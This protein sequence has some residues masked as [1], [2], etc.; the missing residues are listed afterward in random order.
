[1]F[2][3]IKWRSYKIGTYWLNKLL[4]IQTLIGKKSPIIEHN[5]MIEV[6]LVFRWLYD[7]MKL[8]NL[9]K[10]LV[11]PIYFFDFYN[12]IVCM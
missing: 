9:I 2:K 11:Y 7:I 4:N 3:I 6:I 10:L 12:Y 8:Q 1:M 5:N